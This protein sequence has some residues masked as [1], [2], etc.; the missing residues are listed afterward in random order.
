MACY[1]PN[2]AVD[3]GIDPETHKHRIKFLPRRVDGD[4]ASFRSKY[5]DSLM[6]MPCGHCV[7]CAQDY[8]REWQCRIMCEAE[9][10]EKACFLTL[11]YSSKP[12]RVPLRDHLRQFIRDIR[13]YLRNNHLS[14]K[15]LKFFGSGELGETT[16]RSHYHLILFG[17]DFSEDREVVS[18]RGLNFIYRSKLAEKLWSHGFVSIGSLDVASAGYVSKYCDKKKLS[19][20]DSGEF[21]IMSRGLGRR[22]FFDHKNEI[23]NSDYLYFQGNQF[24]IPRYFLTL[25]D[26]TDVYV[27]ADDLKA[28]KKIKALNF[29]YNRIKSFTLEEYAMLDTAELNMKKKVFKE[30]VRDV[31]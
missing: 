11:T 12:P 31:Y 13:D 9:Y 20:I 30:G 21:I 29:R 2:L 3:F 5:G 26:D 8:A 25:A 10:Y 28:R 6:L 17:V 7:G 22:Y 15:N 4:L 24:K 23:F 27:Y 14:Y 1:H 19:G 18:K 16:H